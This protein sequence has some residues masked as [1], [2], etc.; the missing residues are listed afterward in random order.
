MKIDDIAS[1]FDS[2]FASLKYDTKS[3]EEAMAAAVRDMRPS[4]VLAVKNQ[5]SAILKGS[6]LT[7]ESEKFAESAHRFGFQVEKVEM[8]QLL[9]LAVEKLAV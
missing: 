9:Q 1:L 4:K 6:D 8:R 7:A 5:L 2:I 3:I